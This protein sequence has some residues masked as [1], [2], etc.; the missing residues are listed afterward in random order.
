MIEIIE[1]NIFFILIIFFL[2]FL[3][4]NIL[5]ETR[6][7]KERERTTNFFKGK[8]AENLEEVIAEIFKKQKNTEEKVHKALNRIKQLDKAALHSI[9]KVGVVRFNPFSDIGS[10]QSFA[11]AL[12]DQKDDGVVISSLHA[13]DGTRIYLKPIKHGESKYPLSK[14]EEEAIRKAVSEQS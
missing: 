12:L 7:K 4:W 10:N 8:K 2:F 5:I 13:K 1:K 9:Q 11:I 14:E 6:L 3:I